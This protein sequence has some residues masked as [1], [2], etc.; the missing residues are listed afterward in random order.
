MDYRAQPVLGI[1]IQ[2]FLQKVTPLLDIQLIHSYLKLGCSSCMQHPHD[3]RHLPSASCMHFEL[4]LTQLRTRHIWARLLLAVL[5]WRQIYWGSQ[6]YVP[7]AQVCRVVT[8]RGT[9]N[10]SFPYHPSSVHPASCQDQSAVQEDSC[11]TL[12]C[13]G[14]A[15]PAQTESSTPHGLPSM[16]V[17]LHTS[18]S[19]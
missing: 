15:A 9:T 3:L 8:G 18:C 19:L 10:I 7:T 16:C 11:S 6:E 5:I 13:A 12:E 1:E 14:V 4:H 2:N 17:L